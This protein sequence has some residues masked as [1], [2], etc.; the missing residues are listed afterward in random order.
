MEKAEKRNLSLFL[1]Y[2]IDRKPLIMGWIQRKLSKHVDAQP[3]QPIWAQHPHIQV[4]AQGSQANVFKVRIGGNL[5]EKFRIPFGKKFWSYDIS[6]GA[7]S[8]LLNSKFD[9]KYVNI[10]PIR[11]NSADYKITMFR[12]TWEQGDLVCDEF[13]GTIKG[14]TLKGKFRRKFDDKFEVSHPGANITGDY[15]HYTN[16]SADINDDKSVYGLGP[17]NPSVFSTS[18][19]DKSISLLGLNTGQVVNFTTDNNETY[20]FI[21]T[22]SYKE[23]GGVINLTELTHGQNVVSIAWEDLRG[24][25]GSYSATDF[26]AHTTIAIGECVDIPKLFASDVR[27]LV[28]QIEVSNDTPQVQAPVNT[29]FQPQLLKF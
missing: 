2:I 3:E 10:E 28:T 6:S 4:L 20:S 23:T 7:L 26:D 5:I 21:V 1:S 27:G 16:T 29:Q 14:G 12:G 18:T 19:S 17:Y 11:H 25:S 13:I 9:A 8:F 22:N 24:R 15:N